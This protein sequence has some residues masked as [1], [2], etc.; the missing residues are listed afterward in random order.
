[1]HVQAEGVV[2]PGDVLELVLHA[3]IV[4]GVDDLLLLPRAPRVRARRPEKGVVPGRQ[5][6]QARARLALPGHRVAEGLAA[7]RADLD[8]ALDQLAGDR[9][10]Q[11]RVLL[12]EVAEL[13]E[14]VVERVRLRVE[15]RE[16]LLDPDREVG[17]GLED[18]S[19][20][21]HVE[22]GSGPQVR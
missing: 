7:A 6:E 21:R 10:R 19:D 22:H 1:V 11:H 8:L 17:G 13:L 3:P 15:D 2:P 4:V 20:S 12:R 9:L 18:L 14:A 5:G 16:L